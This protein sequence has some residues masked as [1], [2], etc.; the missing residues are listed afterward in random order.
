MN[1]NSFLKTESEFSSSDQFID[2]SLYT[3][4]TEEYRQARKRRQNR[5]SASRVRAQKKKE[6]DEIQQK[7]ANLKEFSSTLQLELFKLKLE[8]EKLKAESTILD[9][10]SQFYSRIA[11]ACCIFF[12]F[13]LQIYNS[14]P[15]EVGFLSQIWLYVL[16]FLIPILIILNK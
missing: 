9:K 15:P 8:N 14:T 12:I 5:E 13:C 7:I 10:G 3:P 6:F 11:I 2:E 16:S 4:G 1:L